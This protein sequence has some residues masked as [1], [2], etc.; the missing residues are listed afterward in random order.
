MYA[1][2]GHYF[3]RLFTA[4]D[5][6]ASWI[7]DQIFSMALRKFSPLGTLRW[8]VS[9]YYASRYAKLSSRPVP[10]AS[11]RLRGNFTSFIS[12]LPT[13]FDTLLVPHANKIAPYSAM[14]I[15]PSKPSPCYSLTRI[16]HQNPSLLA[17]M[18]SCATHSLREANERAE[19]C[20]L[21]HDI[22]HSMA[23]EQLRD[24][25]YLVRNI[26][27]YPSQIRNAPTG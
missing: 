24:T 26:K 8:Y 16:P 25:P 17:P 3:R 15:S 2:W 14:P 1:Q 7:P 6:V 5:T 27:T 12:A 23:A 21:F 10:G 20:Y 22:T 9:P 18:T 4:L 19:K 11:K 13:L